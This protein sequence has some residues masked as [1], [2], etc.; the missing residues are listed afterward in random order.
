MLILKQGFEKP[1]TNRYWGR[2]KFYT[3]VVFFLFFGDEKTFIKPFEV[4][5]RSV[6][7]KI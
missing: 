7:I 3:K 1:A 2:G 5:Q 4:P 6:K